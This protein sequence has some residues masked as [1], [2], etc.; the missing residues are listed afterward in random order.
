[1]IGAWMGRRV[2]LLLVEVHA[3]RA[4]SDPEVHAIVDVGAMKVVVVMSGGG[5]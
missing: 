2:L 1:M 4:V 3:L 5:A